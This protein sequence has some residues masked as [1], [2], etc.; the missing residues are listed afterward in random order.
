MVVRMCVRMCVSLFFWSKWC[1]YHINVFDI[2]ESCL[3]GFRVVGIS[4]NNFITFF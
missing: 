4:F 1:I 2:L 3:V